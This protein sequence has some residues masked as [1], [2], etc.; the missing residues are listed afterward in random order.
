[1]RKIR[2]R[3]Q[4]DLH[5]FMKNVFCIYSLFF[6]PYY[7]M[8]LLPVSNGILV[9][10]WNQF[11]T[12]IFGLTSVWLY[13]N[14]KACFHYCGEISTPISKSTS[15]GILLK[16][17]VHMQRGRTCLYF[18][19]ITSI[20]VPLWVVAINAKKYFSR[21][22]ALM[23]KGNLIFGWYQWTAVWVVYCVRMLK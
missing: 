1:M 14:I 12:L 22:K 17:F 21:M 9:L 11:A 10:E 8:V 4:I 16:V 3:V 7:I 5:Y 23:T 13:V 6:F 18:A 15:L 2:V 20:V 19:C